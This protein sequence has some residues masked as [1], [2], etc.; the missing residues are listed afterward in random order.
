MHFTQ[1]ISWIGFTT[2]LCISIPQIVKTIRTRDVKGVSAFTFVLITI[3]AT[4]FFVRSLVI[5]EYALIAYYLIIMI[6]SVIQL[7]LIVR[8]R[9]R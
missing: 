2:G 7:M 1:I 6:A 4:C 8:F 5:Q 3:T 9:K